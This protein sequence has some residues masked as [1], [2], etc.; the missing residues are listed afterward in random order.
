MKNTLLCILSLLLSLPLQA[1]MPKHEVR[2]VWLTTL[3]GLDWPRS[4][5]AAVQKHELCAVLDSFQRAGINTVL[6]QTR[7]RATT[8]FPSDIEPW[9][10]VFTGRPGASPGYDPLQLAVDE[11][12]R[13]GMELH[14]WVVALPVG[15][16]NDPGCRELRRRQPSLL[17]KIGDEGF[18]NPE[19][20]GVAPYLARFC[21]DI[22]RRYDVDGIHLDYIRY[23]DQWPRAHTAAEAARRRSRITAIVS[24]V[25]QA[26]KTA[27]PWVKMS[28]SPVGK[29]DDLLRYSSGGWNART[30]VGQDAQQWLRLGY[31]DQLYPMQYFRNNQF[32]PFAIDWQENACGRTIA[33]GLGIYFLDPS[34]GSWVLTD[35]TRQMHVARQI[36]SGHC[37]FRSKFLLSD[38]KGIYRFTCQFNAT[39]ALTPPMTWMQRPAPLP[40]A[41][42]ALRGNLL[43][44]DEAEN[45]S[46]SPYLLYNIYASDTYPVDVTCAE[47]LVATHQARTTLRVPATPRRFYAV[48]A[49]D[50]YGQESMPCQMKSPVSMEGQPWLVADDIQ[51]T[52]GRHLLLP[53]KPSTLEADLIAVESLH[54]QT[55]TLLPYDDEKAWIGHLP[56]G[57]YSLRAI[58]KKRVSHRLGYFSIRRKTP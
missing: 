35:V 54:G 57:I 51:R 33:A 41:R 34:E 55:I 16:W 47:H 39:P 43:I 36:G 29:Y 25:S 5:S 9:Y 52:D 38:V 30:A 24:A 1:R 4:R 18:M 22:V 10:Y 2:A 13:R 11:C 58:G 7:V 37:F 53:L 49:C 45:R 31:M 48:T 23:P 8:I 40:P 17:K 14:A 46:D 20:P 42:L 44:W 6:L 27:K 32:F 56:D 15:K 3:N 50:R 28:C 26:V 19:Q 21:A 12:H